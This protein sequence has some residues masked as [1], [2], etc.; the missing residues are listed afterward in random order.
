MYG[1][2][3]LSWLSED[4]FPLLRASSYSGL[5]HLFGNHLL[6]FSLC[7]SLL[8]ISL[9]IT[10]SRPSVTVSVSNQSNLHRTRRRLCSAAVSAVRRLQNRELKYG[11][12]CSPLVTP[13]ASG[14]ILASLQHVH[15]I[16]KERPHKSS[17]FSHRLISIHG[18]V[19]CCG[20]RRS[21]H[22]RPRIQPCVYT[23]TNTRTQGRTHCS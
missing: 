2:S 9:P 14:S 7:C 5:G 12:S 11:V 21:E 4:E 13:A 1:L 3:W 18:L 17:T 6:A 20:L 22:T 19:L 10:Y 8:R 23:H 16:P 15:L